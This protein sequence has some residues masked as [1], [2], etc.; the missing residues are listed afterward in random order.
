M[1]DL[2]C[3]DGE[4]WEGVDLNFDKLAGLAAAAIRAEERPVTVI[5]HDWGAY[6]AS[7]VLTEHPE[8]IERLVL[9]DV[10]AFSL[11]W[12]NPKGLL[13]G[14]GI[15]CYQGINI[16]IYLL[17]RSRWR[18][19]R[20]LANAINGVWAPALCA[21]SGSWDDYGRVT[22]SNVNHFYANFVSRFARSEGHK[23][24]VATLRSPPAP[25]L[26]LYGSGWFH[27]PQ[28]ESALRSAEWPECDA[29]FI[30]RGHWFFRTFEGRALTAST[31][32]RWMGGDQQPPSNHRLRRQTIAMEILW[33]PKFGPTFSHGRFRG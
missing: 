4:P 21:A 25:L 31:I 23:R 10:G 19:L 30:E 28:W 32:I 33:G 5:A 15:V 27:D 12:S 17:G 14:L 18:P 11:R 29:A 9:L 2:P 6:V 7:I 26:F 13:T 3:C 1:L 24:M 16:L 8:L 22:S 20:R